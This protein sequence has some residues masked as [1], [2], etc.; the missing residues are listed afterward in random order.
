MYSTPRMLMG[1]YPFE[2]HGL[3]QLRPVDERLSYVVPE[4]TRAQFVYFR[5]GNSTDEMIYAALLR[6][7]ESMRLFP[8]SARGGC[9]VP[10]AVIEDLLPG[11]RL[12]IFV[13]APAGVS[14]ML[15]VDVGF[16]ETEE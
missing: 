11:T 5:G 14:G 10:L 15:V 8:I 3:D 7:G 2:G 16:V 13:G 1:A 6:N 12:E 9:H 4:G